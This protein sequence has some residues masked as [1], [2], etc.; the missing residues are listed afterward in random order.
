MFYFE[1]AKSP[2]TLADVFRDTTFLGRFGLKMVDNA[3]CFR[4]HQE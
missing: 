2:L 1:N 3:V 4:T